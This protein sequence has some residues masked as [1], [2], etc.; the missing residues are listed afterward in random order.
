[1][2]NASILNML[3]VL[4]FHDDGLSISN[5]KGAN[6]FNLLCKW[7]MMNVGGMGAFNRRFSND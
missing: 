4:E 7:K 2:W 1:M 5:L 6:I 3:D